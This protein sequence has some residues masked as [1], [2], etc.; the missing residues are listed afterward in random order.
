M[1]FNFLIL[2]FFLGIIGMFGQTTIKGIVFD[3]L[4]NP[5]PGAS[6]I[7]KNTKIGTQT[8][9]DGKFQIQISG[10]KA[11]LQ[12]SYIG[13]KTYELEVSNQKD[14]KIYLTLDTET[15]DE[16]V[17]I[18][19]GE[20]NKKDLTG[21]ITNLKTSDDAKNLAS[22]LE[23]LIQGRASGVY[24]N[25]S[26]FEPTS[27]A[28]I[29]IRGINSLTGNTQPLYV[30][31][32]IIISS[33]TED[34][35]DPLQGGNSYMSPQSGLLGIN[36]KD[37]A[38]IQILKDASATA[39]YGSRGSNGV[40]II[41]TK[42]GKTGKPKFNYVVTSKIGVQ[43]KEIDVLNINDYVNYINNSRALKGWEPSY[44]TYSDGSI[45]QYVTSE[46]YM[47]DNTATLPRLQGVNWNE[48]IYKPSYSMN[49]HLSVSGG[50]E[51]NK[52]YFSG[53]FIKSD[54]LVSRAYAK[55]TDFGL[56]LENKLTER[57]KFD[58]KISFTY[59]DNSASKGTENL[60]GTN[61][62]ITS[63][64]VQATPILNFA[65]NNQNATDIEE[66]I[67]GPRAWIVD[68]DDLAKDVR[69][70]GSF[71]AEYKLSDVFKLKTLV[72]I[73]YRSK[74]RKIWYGTS[75]FR[76]LQVNGE[77]GLSQFN[78]FRYNIDN[79]LMFNKKFANKH[80]INGTIGVIYDAVKSK[81]ATY[82]A[83][84]FALKDLRADGIM[85][86]ENYQHLI[87]YTLPENILSF[88]GRLNYSYKNRYYFTSTF[89]ADGSSK[90]SEENRF[91]YFP[92]FAVS[93]NM[94]NEKFLK[95][96]SKLNTAKIRLG[97]GLTGNA[98]IPPYQTITPYGPTANP[99]T[100]ANG[101]AVTTLIPT[102]L[103]NPD[104]KW[105]T[106]SQ[107]SAGFDF[108]FYDNRLTGSIEAYHKRTYDLLQ[109][110]N[111]APSTGFQKIT[112]NQGD[113]ENKGI[114]LSLGVDVVKNENNN[115]N[116]YGNISTYKTKIL[117]LGLPESQFGNQ[118]FSAFLGN[119]ISGGNYFKVPANIFIEGQEAGLFWGYQTN[120]IINNADILATA[121]AVRG[122]APQLGDIYYIDQNGDGNVDDKDLTVIGNP[123]PDFTVGFGMDYTYK[124]FNINVFFNG[125]FGNEIANGNLLREDY[126]S[127]TSSANVRTE[128][129]IDAWSVDNVDSDRPRVNYDLI[130]EMGFMDRI[131]EDGS[132][133]RLSNITLK[134]RLPEIKNNKI[135]ES[136]EF[137]LSGSNLWLWTDYSGYD[138]EVNSFSFDPM[139]KGIDWMSFPNQRY[140]TLGFN[141]NF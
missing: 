51:N 9:F 73:D 57:L 27:P 42:S 138:P 49:H 121:P 110:I 98:N 16:V 69:S 77:A 85:N 135:F 132:Y 48:D 65:E 31:D 39:I 72:G 47:L 18:G 124:N 19:Y 105:E 87:Y 40:I 33:A 112:A 21:S 118:V 22:G 67:D 17:V 97:W 78:R 119:Q 90:F 120:G 136:M 94:H 43:S 107:Y 2:Y 75:L 20:V 64:I 11:V 60:G 26:S 62:N 95:D 127:G 109:F 45:A 82:M 103:A 37:I 122:I 84:G 140:F 113:L 115:F 99:Y 6:V 24:V 35:A 102:Q 54:G 114:E 50:N 55:N 79:T 111:V 61:Y 108:G 58:T 44:Y 100:N 8:D 125:V 71:S 56:K 80:N 32:G 7:V 104:I 126:A 1:K 30:V 116:V 129:F 117:N 70:L 74:E 3:E 130:D 15:L 59:S 12:F 10:E 66:I 52:Y 13:Y 63:Q 92:S 91:S 101:S 137:S 141:V 36:P 23:S 4:N 53:G 86:G 68:Y 46:Q 83:T 128:A 139:R 134:Y 93:W 131:V 34:A 123:N 38:D 106:T 133:I 81:N 96:F 5:L 29:Q 25:S 89:R 14:L 76:G 28:S 88:I 41:T